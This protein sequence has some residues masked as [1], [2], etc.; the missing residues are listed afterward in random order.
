MLKSLANKMVGIFL[1]DP[2]Q[3]PFLVRIQLIFSF[4]GAPMGFLRQK[5]DGTT[6]L[7]ILVEGTGVIPG[8][9]KRPVLL[10]QLTGK[11]TE[12]SG[13]MQGFREDRR[14]VAKPVK[15]LYYG[16]FGSYAPS[17]DS[18]FSNL[19][20]DE[21]DLVYQTYGSDAAVQYSESILDFAKDND[22]TVWMVDSL[23]DLLTGGEHTKTKR[24]LDEK[25]QLREE[26]EA[27]RTVLETKPHETVK[28]NV[29]ELKSLSGLGIDVAFL[30]NMEEEIRLS[31]ECVE[32]Q[33]RLVSMSQLLEKLQKVQNQRLS[34]PLPQH[35]SQL[36]QP[37]EEETALASSITDNLTDIAKRVNPGDVAPAAGLRKAMGVALID[38]DNPAGV[39]VLDLESELR[40][41]L[42]SEPSLS[43]SPLRDDKTIEEILME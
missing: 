25:K 6:H 22:Y 7:N 14:N 12:G 21:S 15:P 11:L 43:H 34:Q 29:D 9:K 19:S 20:K 41:F 17:Y 39:D 33:Q 13:Q 38:A 2:F 24:I 4:T 28:I 3:T 10:G 42:E 31:E 30:Q 27:V 40:Q 37:S 8:T 26:E 16:A 36:P 35:L 18:A 23:L 32:L 1:K 5:K